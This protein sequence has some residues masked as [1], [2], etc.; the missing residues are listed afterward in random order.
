M[1]GRLVK[2]LWSRLVGNTA[3]KE[4]EPI[5]SRQVRRFEARKGTLKDRTRKQP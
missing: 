5:K 1:I 2:G 4:P 3:N